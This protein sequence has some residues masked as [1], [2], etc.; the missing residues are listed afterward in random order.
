VAASTP[1]AGTGSGTSPEQAG[2]LKP[3]Q[4]FAGRYHI[5]RLLGLG[6][7]GAVYQAWDDALAVVVAL[8]VIRPEI[9]GDP[10]AAQAIERRFKQELLLARQVTHKNVVRIHDLGD[11]DGIKYITMPFINGE[12]LASILEREGTLPAPRALKIARSFIS[13][14]IAAHEAG[15]VHRDLKPAN[16]MIDPEGEALITDFGIARSTGPT[17]SATAPADL[18]PAHGTLPAVFAAQTVL[19]AVVGTI[20]YMAPEQAKAQPVDQR[21]DI[22]STGLILYDMLGGRVRIERA[23]NP[24]A[25]LMGRTTEAPPLLRTINPDVPEAMEQ[26]INRCLQPDAAA[27]F[28]TSTELAEALNR[29]DDNG[30]PLPLP[31]QLLKSVRFWAAA[32]V[33]AVGIAT[34]TWFIADRTPPPIPDPVAVLVADF[35]NKTGEPVFDGLME[36]SVTVGMEGASFISAVPRKEAVQ[37]AR[38][39]KAGTTLDES[40]ARLVALRQGIKV[41]VLGSIEKRGAG[42]RLAIQGVD[43]TSRKVLFSDTA[44]ARDRDSVLKASAGLASKARSAL[45]DTQPV[46]AKETFSSASL[47]AVNAYTRAQELSIAGKDQD[48]IEYYKKAVSIDPAFGRAYGG[49]AMSTTRLGRHEEAAKLWQESL[50]H[51]DVMS[52]REKYRLLGAYYTLVTKNVDTARDTY[53]QLVK[54]YPAD[55]AGHNGLAVALFNGLDFAGALKEVAEARKIYPNNALYRSNYALFA[56]YAGDF[57]QAAQEA[58]RIVDDGTASFDTYLP[59][60]ISAIADG[61]LSDARKAYTN[62]SAVDEAGASLAPAGLADMALAEGRPAEAIALLEPAIK[63]DQEDKN[64]AGVAIKQLILADALG[65]QGNV[66]AAVESARRALTNNPGD[67]AYILPTVRWLIAANQIEEAAK[68]GAQLD[69]K[70]APQARAYGRVVA[71]QVA[72]ARGHYVDAVDALREV[73]AKTDLWLVRFNLGLAYLDAGAPVEALREFELCQTRRGEGYAVFLDDIPT[74]RAVAPLRY[75]IG[76]AREAQ[77]LTAQAVSDYQTFASGYASDSPEPLVQDARKRLAALR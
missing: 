67:P 64:D 9:A 40:T 61:K 6:G 3:G 43:P 21:A 11:V 57:N 58:R 48:A 71:A 69:Q 34:A 59:I 8:K 45:G 31:V 24:V 30:V 41:V 18:V 62:M 66:K 74:A 35:S 17:P 33:A 54:E 15:I 52:P 46:D 10:E 32:A 42:Y 19:G 63:K 50:K 1:V 29:L 73:P 49:L 51:T 76:R 25:E 47:E 26:I 7:M 23:E 4:P 53:K 12:D 44:D 16:I 77:S 13:G 5:V 55:G 37:T 38:L 75:W 28:Q 70:L 14:L 20:G 56:M 22:Y 27:R 39:I 2:P 68:L 65:M 60:A 36:Q 72:R